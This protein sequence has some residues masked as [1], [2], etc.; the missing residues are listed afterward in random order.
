MTDE[1]KRIVDALRYCNNQNDCRNCVYDKTE[2]DCVENMEYAAIKLIEKQ[3]A[4][5]E[6][7]NNR[8]ADSICAAMYNG[9]AAVSRVEK[10]RNENEELRNQVYNL[11]L[12][13]RES[14]DATHGTVGF[15]VRNVLDERHPG[16]PGYNPEILEV[17]K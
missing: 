8:I 17:Q 9:Q 1:A 13:L 2:G 3:D 12:Y 15:A 5:I 10:L 6:E 16:I 7:L 14:M 11:T 4:E